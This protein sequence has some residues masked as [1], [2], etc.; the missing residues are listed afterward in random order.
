MELQEYRPARFRLERGLSQEGLSP[1]ST[2]FSPVST[3]FSPVSTFTGISPLSTQKLRPSTAGSG[4]LRLSSTNPT[5]PSN[6]RRSPSSVQSPQNGKRPAWVNDWWKTVTTDN[7]A[8]HPHHRHYFDRR[9]LETSYRKRPEIY[10]T[11]PVYMPHTPKHKGFIYRAMTSPALN[12]NPPGTELDPFDLSNKYRGSIQWGDR[13]K[14]CGTDPKAKSPTKG[15]KIPWVCDHHNL[16]S[17]DNSLVNPI[18]RHYFEENYKQ[19]NG[20]VQ[21][22]LESSFKNRGRVSGRPIKGRKRAASAG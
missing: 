5:S 1:L 11:S 6:D 12:T 16:E 15:V 9:G 13:I 22:G 4:D 21:N 2:G 18:C 8:L 20:H 14:L 7:E 10:A 17:V 19:L 3:G